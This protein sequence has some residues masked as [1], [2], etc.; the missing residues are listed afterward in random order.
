MFALAIGSLP[1]LIKRMLNVEQVFFLNLVDAENGCERFCLVRFLIACVYI[2]AEINVR[3]LM[4]EFS[5]E[6]FPFFGEL[7][8]EL[9][10]LF[11][12]EHSKKIEEQIRLVNRRLYIFSRTDNKKHGNLGEEAHC[13]VFALN[14]SA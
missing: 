11:F 9:L 1:D 3:I 14:F 10:K 2:V 7:L 6:H 8:L 5:R 12:G 13:T 4:G